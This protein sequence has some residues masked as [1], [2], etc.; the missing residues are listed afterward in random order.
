MSPQWERKE[1]T[2]AKTSLR[3]PP[4]DKQTGQWLTQENGMKS[5]VFLQGNCAAPLSQFQPSLG[6]QGQQDERD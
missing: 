3:L 5:A 1:I 6:S 4:L 2:L